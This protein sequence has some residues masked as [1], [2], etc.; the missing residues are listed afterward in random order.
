MTGP[1]VLASYGWGLLSLTH[2]VLSYG[3]YFSIMLL[4]FFSFD[5]AVLT[6]LLMICNGES[7]LQKQLNDKK[8]IIRLNYNG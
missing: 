2:F 1:K 3:R 7:K 6:F 5:N 8:K 4:C